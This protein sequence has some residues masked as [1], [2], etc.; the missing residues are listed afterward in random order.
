MEGVK[1][2]KATD[3]VLCLVPPPAK[4]I[5]GRREGPNLALLSIVSRHKVAQVV[6]PLPVGF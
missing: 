1:A 6:N 4:Q 3:V 2:G 5:K